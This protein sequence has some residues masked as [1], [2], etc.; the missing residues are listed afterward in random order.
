MCDCGAV[1]STP[2]CSGP[3]T[4][5]QTTACGPNISTMMMVIVMMMMMMMMLMFQCMV[6]LG[7]RCLSEVDIGI[8]NNGSDDNDDDHDVGGGDVDDDDDV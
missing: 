7:K 8:S 1:T 6:K 5:N 2:I 3:L 4:L